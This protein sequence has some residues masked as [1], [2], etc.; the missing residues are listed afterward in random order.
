[1]IM[2]TLTETTNVKPYLSVTSKGTTL[3]CHIDLQCSESRRRQ[4]DC[5]ANKY[6]MLP[7]HTVPMYH[8]NS[9]TVS[10]T[11]LQLQYYGMA[12]KLHVKYDSFTPPN[13]DGF[14]QLRAH[15]APQTRLQFQPQ[16]HLLDALPSFVRRVTPDNVGLEESLV[17]GQA[18]P[19]L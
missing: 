12:G 16:C 3:P 13:N 15:C 10:T 5:G 9:V 14:V 1:M 2:N 11:I 17:H 8:A 7:Y 19:A 18:H 6:G 4:R